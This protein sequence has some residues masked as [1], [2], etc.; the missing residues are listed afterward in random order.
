MRTQPAQHS[1]PAAVEVSSRVAFRSATR[2]SMGPGKLVTVLE[3]ALEPLVLVASLWGVALALEGQLAGS[4][5]LLAVV[6]FS[7]TFP[8]EARLSQPK[9]RVV[10]D[11]V[12]GWLVLAGLLGLFGYVSGY[13]EYFN[14]ETLFTWA[15]IAP[16]CQL[17]AH[18]ALRA[19]LPAVR[20]LQGGPNFA[21]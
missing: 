8:C 1:L 2:M 6:V 16:W 7:L 18:F 13:L 5:M 21:L 11:I 14:R 20:S 19:A 9:G 3:M 15:W 17:G 4:H 12:S 10:V